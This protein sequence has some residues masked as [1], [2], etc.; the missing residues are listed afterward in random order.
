MPERKATFKKEERL[1]SV[2]AIG[3]LFGSGLSHFCFP[4]K[5]FYKPNNLE[6]CRV[7]ISVPKR[8]HKRAVERNLLKR[9]IRESYRLNKEMLSGMAGMDIAVVYLASGICE[10]PEI[11]KSLK[12]ALARLKENCTKDSGTPVHNSD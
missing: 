12:N 1:S 10:F 7:V 5:L 6:Y 11:D 9:R 4:F 8:Q 3:T 2:T